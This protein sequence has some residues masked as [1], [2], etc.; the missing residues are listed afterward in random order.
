MTPKA[1]VQLAKEAM[2]KAYA[3]NKKIKSNTNIIC[4]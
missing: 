4:S 3:E 2:Q 1:L